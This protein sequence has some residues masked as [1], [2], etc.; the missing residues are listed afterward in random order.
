MSKHNQG[1]KPGRRVLMLIENLSFPMDR[2]MRQEAI[3]LRGAGY[4]VNVICP[5]G[6]SQDRDGFQMYEGIRV[7][8]YPLYWQASSAL[9]YLL[10]YSWA[11]L[12]TCLLMIWIWVRHG[13]DYV[14]AANPPDLFALLFMPFGLIGKKFVY[15]QHD[16]CPETY[17]SKFHRQD[18]VYR[19]LVRLERHSYQ[20]A[21]LVLATNQSFRDIA[22]S[23]GNVPPEK[24]VIVRSGPDLNH[25]Q[26][27]VPVPQLKRGFPYMVAYLGVM[28]VQDG[29]D[30]VVSAAHH[31]QQLRGCPDVLFALIGKGDQWETLRQQAKDLGLNGTIHFTG[32][33]PDAELLQYL[34]TA[35]VCVAPD[36]PIPLNHMST[37]N[38]ILEYMACGKPIVSFDLVESR[39]SAGEAAVYVDR[40]DPRRLAQE[41]NALL[42]NPIRRH[43]IG[44]CGRKRVVSELDWSH[45]ARALVEA[46]ACLSGSSTK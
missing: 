27:T 33:I 18:W 4:A 20:T 6:D 7:Y 24:V 38:K 15:D 44:E 8:R 12:C 43:S 32:R 13:F 30:R 31:L 16:L 34:S 25:F 26:P 14:H 9:E 19:L 22:R 11:M 28:S 46:Y 37:M 23:R 41:V 36:P 17:Q 29:V 45:S 42:D 3:A 5:R 40:D 21:S 1:S 10:E 39:R 2:R 35:D